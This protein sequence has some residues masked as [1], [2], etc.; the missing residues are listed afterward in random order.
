[1][2]TPLPDRLPKQTSQML[3]RV[4]PEVSAAIRLLARQR[5]CSLGEVVASFVN[6]RSPGIL[7]PEAYLQTE[8]TP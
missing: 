6:C 5:K 3:I 1:M 4:T 8:I 2:P 7:P